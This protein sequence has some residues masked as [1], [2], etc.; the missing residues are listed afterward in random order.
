MTNVSITVDLSTV[1]KRLRY[2]RD[3]RLFLSRPKL[4]D[5]MGIPPTTLKNYELDYR[6]FGSKEA[7]EALWRVPGLSSYAT[8]I[9]SGTTAIPAQINPVEAPVEE[10]KIAA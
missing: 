8:W 5:L 3:S 7:M 4:A 9:L 10:Q 6:E 1:G 2:V